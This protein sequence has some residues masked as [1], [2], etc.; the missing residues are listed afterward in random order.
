MCE[1]RYATHFVHHDAED[2]AHQRARRRTPC[3]STRASPSTLRIDT[4]SADLSA[5]RRAR[6]RALCALTRAPPTSLRIDTRVAVSPLTLSYV[7]RAHAIPHM[8]RDP[9]C[10]EHIR[11]VVRFAYASDHAT[12]RFSDVQSPRWHGATVARRHQSVRRF[13]IIRDPPASERSRVQLRLWHSNRYRHNTYRH[14]HTH[15][16]ISR[17]KRDVVRSSKC[18]RVSTHAIVAVIRVS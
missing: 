10:A 15:T 1:G 9:A 13:R 12:R 4:R 16:H 17:C 8:W 14:A 18:M 2:S 7:W 5:H 3:A 11:I 6:R